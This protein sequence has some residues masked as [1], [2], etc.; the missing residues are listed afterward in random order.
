MGFLSCC[1]TR[2]EA[3]PCKS[4][5]KADRFID[6]FETLPLDTAVWG[7]EI[8]GEDR[9]QLESSRVIEGMSSIKFTLHSDDFVNGGERAE[10]SL[11]DSDPLCSEAWYRWS[12]MVPEEYIDTPDARW[13][14]FGQWHDQPEEGQSWDDFPN[15]SPMIGVYYG[16]ETTDDPDYGIKV[17]YGLHENNRPVFDDGFTIE[18]GRWYTLKFHIL[19]SRSDD[20]FI[21]LWIDG[22]RVTPYNGTDYKLY[23]ANMYNSAP[24]Y[25]KLGIYRDPDVDTTNSIYYDDFRSGGSEAALH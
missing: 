20:G 11:I 18:K 5:T 23:G 17:Y 3:V 24:A 21:E 4:I 25:L 12:F 14:L 7:C 1:S 15:H 2:E 10:I 9:L 8:A 16:H 22:E 6:G 19:W 13:T